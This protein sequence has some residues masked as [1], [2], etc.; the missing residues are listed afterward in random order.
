MVSGHAR[1]PGLPPDRSRPAD[2]AVHL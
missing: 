1:P 2:P